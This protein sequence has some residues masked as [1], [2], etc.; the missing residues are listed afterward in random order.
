MV[1]DV[2]VYDVDAQLEAATAGGTVVTKAKLE[3]AAGLV[4]V[5]LKAPVF[6]EDLILNLRGEG[7]VYG[8]GNELF[9]FRGELGWSIAKNV[10]LFGGYRWLQIKFDEEDFTV[11]A[12]LKGP[13][14]ALQAEF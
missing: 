6:A 14:V 12:A 1:W 5:A 4:G 10:L 13:Y 2:H 7:M 11:D 9:D 8:E 3:S